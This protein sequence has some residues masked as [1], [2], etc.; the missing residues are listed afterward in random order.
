M[1]PS[2]SFVPELVPILSSGKHRSP[3]KGACLME[4]VSLLAGERWSDHPGCTHSLLATLARHVNDCTSDQARSR[5]AVLAPSMVGLAGDE[6][7]VEV[8][9]A[10]RCARTA[11][12]VV[13]AE[14]QR[15]MAVAILAG[16]R[17]LDELDRRPTG[18]LEEASRS[19]LSQAPRAAASAREF[20]ARHRVTPTSFR[21]NAAAHI[22]SSA[23][24]GIGQ[25]C[26]SDRDQLLYDL[27]VG[28]IDDCRR[29]M[30]RGQGSTAVDLSQWDEV[31]RLTGVTAHSG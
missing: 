7:Q 30:H 10:L 17:V 2:G 24:T 31:C 28:A 23:V 5:L 11:L 22:V 9:I 26:V 16:E 19:A 13:A 21:R 15:A 27:L 8:R 14:R 29:W 12:P 4:L 3:R 1:S 20:A 6:I 25:A 18:S